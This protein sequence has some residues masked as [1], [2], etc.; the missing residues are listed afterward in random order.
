MKYVPIITLIVSLFTLYLV[1]QTSNAVVEL[2]TSEAFSN[3]QS[4][5]N[6]DQ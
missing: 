1:F 3:S 6:R 5:P 4:D 2:N